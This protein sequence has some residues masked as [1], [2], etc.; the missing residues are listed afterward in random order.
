M[1]FQPP[2]HGKS[3]LISAH[4]PAWHIGTHPD[5]RVIVTSHTQSLAARF[6]GMARDL[7]TQW[8][9]TH[10]GVYVDPDHRARGDW[11]LRGFA[12]GLLAAGIGGPI[13]GSG[14]NLF[15]IDDPVKND[16]EA[17]SVTYRERVWNWWEA[18]ASTRLEPGGIVAVM[19]TRWHEDDLAGRLLKEEGR[20]EE[21]GRWK[22]LSLPAIAEDDDPMGR[23]PGEAL[24]PERWPIEALEQIRQNK[25][26][27]WWGAMYQQTPGL[28][29]E[30]SW[31][32]EYFEDIWAEDWPDDFESSA[33]AVDPALGKGKKKGD[34]SAIVFAGLFEGKLYV[35]CRL[36][37]EPPPKLVEIALS[38]YAAM[39]PNLFACEE[40]GFQTLLGGMFR[41]QRD[42][43]GL[44]AFDCTPL[45]STGDKIVRI[46]AGVTPYLSRNLIR[47][48]RDSP[49]T[50]RLFDQMREIP[51]GQ[52]DDGPDGLE[53]AIRTLRLWNQGR[54][55]DVAGSVLQGSPY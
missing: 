51:H 6:A 28:F 41:Q 15:I 39:Q 18:T 20:I 12:G 33:M 25:T 2:R 22:V 55:G 35:D 38:W 44:T 48:R 1:V 14:A 47:L 42:E 49:H 36:V 30:A 53:M 5:H 21:G 19:Q 32:P 13:T 26:P 3:L 23:E 24:W 34:Y 43:M 40:N 31:P 52:H 8:G 4:Y 11:Q 50:R 29:G 37:R 16:E 17:I 7:L 45:I 54:G 27:Y 10:F 46:E 9:P